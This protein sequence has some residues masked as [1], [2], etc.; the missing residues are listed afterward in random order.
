[1]QPNRVAIFIDNS[2]VFHNIRKL[3]QHD[4]TWETLYDPKILALKLAG[5][6]N[7]VFIGFYCSR[8]PHY[9]LFEGEQSKERFMMTS[10]YYEKIEGM[11]NI[12]IR[13]GDLKGNK[14]DMVEKNL[15]TQIV[16]DIVTMA[17]LNKYDTAILVSNDGD[18]KSALENIRLFGKRTEVVYFKGSLSMSLRNVSDVTRRARRSY[19]IKT[20]PFN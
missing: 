4:M 11:P 18:F 8:P 6:R 19:F 1:M 9:L 14:G 17:A 10:R 20:W 2:N 12:T 15:D 3:K 7:I 5:G 13:Y 16:T